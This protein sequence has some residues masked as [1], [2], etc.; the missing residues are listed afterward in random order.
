MRYAHKVALVTLVVPLFVAACSPEPKAPDLST[1][2]AFAKSVMTAAASGSV[3]QVEKLV[4]QDR[5]D[6]R[7][8]AQKLVDEANG[9]DPAAWK[10][11]IHNFVPEYA[12][13]NVAQE[14]KPSTIRYDIS[15]TDDHWGL[16][17]GTSKNRPTTG[18]AT[19]G[20]T[21]TSTPKT[22][23]SSK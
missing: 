9:W 18:F 2:E 16:I 22:G 14:G 7:D 12:I 19:P 23:E 3:E 6:V 11:G 5:M 13:V 8:G 15:W 17:L 4:P 21:D 20:P 1:R 10:V